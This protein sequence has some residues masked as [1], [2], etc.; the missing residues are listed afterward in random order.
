[1]SNIDA[2]ESDFGTGKKTFS[3]YLTGIVLCALLTMMPF[4]I[5]MHSVL[6]RTNTLFAIYGFAILQF[7]VQVICFLRLNSKTEQG[8]T[9]IMA[10]IFTVIIL[11]VVVGGSLWIMWNLNSRMM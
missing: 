7:F 9:N 5:V 3:V 11:V 10:F 6:S 2:P 4:Y 8:R 1:M